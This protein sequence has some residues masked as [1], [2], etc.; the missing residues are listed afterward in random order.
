MTRKEWVTQILIL[1]IILKLYHIFILDENIFL[2]FTAKFIEKQVEKAKATA[3]G[4]VQCV[5]I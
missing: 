3:V 2:V 4:Q 5:I 1:F